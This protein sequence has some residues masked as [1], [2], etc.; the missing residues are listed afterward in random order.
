MSSRSKG[1]LFL[2]AV[3]LLIGG[4]LILR[5][6]TG[7]EPTPEERI[8]QALHDA[9]EAAR[10]RDLNGVM[11]L[12]SDDFRSGEL[13]K[14][15]LRLLLSRELRDS[16]GTNYDVH[17]NAPRILPGPKG[18]P[19]QRIVI[20]QA[21]VFWADTGDSIWGSNPITLLMREESERRWLFFTQPRWRIV[22]VNELN[23]PGGSDMSL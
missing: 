17:V 7:P 12:V 23:L 14:Q 5:T 1:V 16:R 9:Q 2:A 11:D 10:N 4:F 13:N 3:F 19:K 15:R 8:A 22:S 6:R 18:D 21:S 20:T